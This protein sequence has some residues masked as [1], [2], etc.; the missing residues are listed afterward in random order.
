MEFSREDLRRLFNEFKSYIS[1]AGAQELLD[2]CGDSERQ[3]TW[4]TCARRWLWSALERVWM[5]IGFPGSIS[6]NVYVEGVTVKG[7]YPARDKVRKLK[8]AIFG[9]K[10]YPDGVILSDDDHII[11][12]ELDHGDKPSKVVRAAAVAYLYT[13]LEGFDKT[14]I[15]FVLEGDLARRNV[16]KDEGIQ[17]LRERLR[18]REV[19]LFLLPLNR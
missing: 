14:L 4:D 3:G 10:P 9:F 2:K 13:L 19:E 18:E 17:E 12:V 8:R 11:A 15:I 5:N 6:K 1:I 16:E 7:P